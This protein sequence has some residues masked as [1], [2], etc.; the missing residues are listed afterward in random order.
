MQRHFFLAGAAAATHMLSPAQERAAV[1]TSPS[2]L[3]AC[4]HG[5]SAT[6]VLMLA[7]KIISPLL[8][9]EPNHGVV[10][11]MLLSL[12]F[13]PKQAQPLS[14]RIC[15]SEHERGC[16]KQD[17]AEDIPGCGVHDRCSCLS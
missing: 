4:E 12:P 5:C 2:L 17:H 3:A 1:P 9:V 8:E 7:L 6:T 13:N 10:R 16:H 15:C 14:F 11:A